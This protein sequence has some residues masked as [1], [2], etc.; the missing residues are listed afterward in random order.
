ML[1]AR[2]CGLEAVGAGVDLEHI[3]DDVGERRFVEARAFV[4]AVAGVEAHL[5]GRNA[6]KR[7]VGRLDIDFGAAPHLRAI[8]TG[9]EENIRQERIVD[10]HQDAGIDDGAV[11]LGEFGGE[12]VEILLV[13]LVVLVDADTR[14]RGRRQKYV[15]VG[16]ASRRRGALDVCDVDAAT[17][18]SPRYLIG[19]TQTT[20]ARPTMAPPIIACLKYSA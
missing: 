18:F 14:R 19:P 3:F 13:G 8:E 5:L 20:G 11:F 16:H 2:I 15:V 7:R 17:N 1:V 10:L 9:L 12:R 4:D 6:G